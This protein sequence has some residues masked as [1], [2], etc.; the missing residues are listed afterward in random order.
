AISDKQSVEDKGRIKLMNEQSSE[1]RNDN[2][3]GGC[4]M[5]IK[6]MFVAYNLGGMCQRS[7]DH[8]TEVEIEENSNISVVYNSSDK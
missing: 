5:L 6:K 2:K 1:I 4:R 3:A 7:V 8:D